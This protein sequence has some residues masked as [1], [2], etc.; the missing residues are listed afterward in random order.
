MLPNGLP[1]SDHMTSDVSTAGAALTPSPRPGIAAAATIRAT[2][3]G[4]QLR[5][6]KP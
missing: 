4:G 6:V 3:S 1:A 2:P 5:G